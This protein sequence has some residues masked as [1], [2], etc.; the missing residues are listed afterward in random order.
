MAKKHSINVYPAPGE[1]EGRALSR[2]LLDPVTK[3]GVTAAVFMDQQGVLPEDLSLDDLVVTL[4]DQIEA[5]LQ[6]RGQEESQEML[7]AQAHTLDMLFH[8]LA[9]WASTTATKNAD[10]FNGLMKLALRAQFQ[11]R[12]TIEALSAIRSPK[13]ANVVQQANIASGHQQVN[14]LG[15][16][17]AAEKDTQNKLLGAEANERLDFRAQEATVKGDKKV[18]AVGGLNGAD[19]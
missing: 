2:S 19:E 12:S 7:A 9:T 1:T 8:T 16:S 11:S 5:M 10:H 3:A 6:S 15:S 17:E 18:E 13:L 14:N 4:G